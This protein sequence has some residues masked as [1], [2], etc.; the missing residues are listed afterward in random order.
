M[1]DLLIPVLL[2]NT[3]PEQ[4][5]RVS[6]LPIHKL[7]KLVPMEVPSTLVLLVTTKREL[8]V[9]E[10]ELVIHSPVQ[11]AQTEEPPMLV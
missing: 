2:V 8:P 4:L 11:L 9:T 7:V 6:P 10:L 1:V 5:A 3:S